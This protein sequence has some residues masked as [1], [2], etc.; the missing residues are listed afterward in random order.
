M[1]AETDIECWDTMKNTHLSYCWEYRDEPEAE[2]MRVH[3]LEHY[4]PYDSVVL[5]NEF[6]VKPDLIEQY[7]CKIWKIP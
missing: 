1:L 7:L 4:H 2:R 3:R 5:K 6:S